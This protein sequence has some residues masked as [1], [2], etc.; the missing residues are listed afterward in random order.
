MA[1]LHALLA[2]YGAFDLS[3]V[4]AND[5]VWTARVE[6]FLPATTGED[7]Q[8]WFSDFRSLVNRLASGVTFPDLPAALDE[9]TDVANGMSGRTDFAI[10]ETGPP[11]LTTTDIAQLLYI[12][13]VGITLAP[14][15]PR[16][17]RAD[18]SPLRESFF[19]YG[20]RETTSHVEAILGLAAEPRTTIY[21][22]A[23]LFEGPRPEEIRRDQIFGLMDLILDQFTGFRSWPRLMTRAYSLGLVS[24]EVSTA[25]IPFAGIVTGGTHPDKGSRATAAVTQI[26]GNYCAV[27]T[28]DSWQVEDGLTVDAV[29]AIVDPRNWA[30]LSPFFCQMDALEPDGR[31]ASQVL[32]HVSTDKESYQLKTALKN[33]KTDFQ[34]GAILNYELADTRVGTGDS[35]LVLVDN[36][37]I[38]IDDN[39]LVDGTVNGV[40]IRTSKMVAI[41][42]TS[43]TATAMFM[44]SLG[45]AAASNAMLFDNAVNPPGGLVPWSIN[46]E[47]PGDETGE[48]AGGT[49][50]Q[51]ASPLPQPPVGATAALVK[52][53]AR[54][55]ADCAQ[56]T[57]TDATNFMNKW[58][59]GGLTIQDLVEY[60]TTVGGRL[61]SEPWRYIAQV[62]KQLTATPSPPNTPQKKAGGGSP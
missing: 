7:Q 15:A 25:S 41:Q 3:V 61:A 8:G 1:A 11:L 23:G 59:K 52:E 32:E 6:E 44:L 53:A 20:R 50:K 55:W 13:A 36:G 19:S 21:R 14:G 57:T 60:T 43:V 22:A 10:P 58:Y 37:Y 49:Q 16:G 17:T 2:T 35:G 26:D 39:K 29:K 51:P 47:R 62:S 34:E 24:F 46:P 48:D 18:F 5:P 31:G 42:G 38:H 45:W 56:A 4:D 28:T 33:W 30:R 9:L 40:R 12:F 27:L 54:M